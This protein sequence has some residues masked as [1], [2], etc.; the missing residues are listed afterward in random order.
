MIYILNVRL[1][2]HAIIELDGEQATTLLQGQITA[3]LANMEIKRANL[4][5]LLT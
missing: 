5:L 3:D 2:N 4:L 1:S